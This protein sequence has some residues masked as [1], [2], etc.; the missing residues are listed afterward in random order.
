MYQK[1]KS[2]ESKVKFRQASNRCRSVFEAA[3]LAYANKAKESI[4][5]QKLG[6]RDFWRIANSVLNEVKSA[7]HPLF[8]GLE[9]LPSASDQVK[10]FG[11][12]FSKNSTL[13]DT[14]I[15]LPVL[16]FRTNLKLHNIS[17]TC[18]MVKKVIMNLDLSKASGPDCIPVVVLKNYKPE[19]S[20]I[21]AEFFNKCLK[22]SCF[23]NCWKISSVVP[24]FKN[25]GER[26][27]VKNYSLL[28]LL[29][30]AL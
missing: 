4:T 6:S 13:D 29:V 27:T 21:L 30:L 16:P 26:S 18:K 5:S 25:V 24:V 7:L 9:V 17:V 11:E 1:D 22:D 15:S 12:N 8:N 14:S 20:C 28:V 3:K 2:F 23:P 10:W 19:L